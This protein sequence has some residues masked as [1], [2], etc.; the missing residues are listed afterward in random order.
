MMRLVKKVMVEH[1]NKR[2]L[3]FYMRLTFILIF[4]LANDVVS[5]VKPHIVFLDS[6]EVDLNKT[7][8]NPKNIKEIKT[9]VGD[10]G[11][12]SR[13]NDTLVITSKNKNHRW[14]TLSEITNKVIKDKLP[15]NF[16]IDYVT[17]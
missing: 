6:V 1:L 12:V 14:V 7:Y 5:Q 9:I 15:V 17:I 11:F 2:Y 8:I 13:L 10:R 16:I 3:L 4:L